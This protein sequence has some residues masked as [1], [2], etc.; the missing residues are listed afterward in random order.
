MN[1]LLNKICISNERQHEEKYFDKKILNIILVLKAK[2][3]L[4]LD[5]DVIRFSLNL[6]EILIHLVYIENISTKYL[7]FLLYELLQKYYSTKIQ[8]RWKYNVMKPLYF[9]KNDISIFV[10]FCA[11]IMALQSDH[12]SKRPI[13]KNVVWEF[14]SDSHQ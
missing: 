4:N 5:L 6:K 13:P 8:W 14:F 7:F 12:L 11:W 1:M 9:T 10:F 2:D 3:F